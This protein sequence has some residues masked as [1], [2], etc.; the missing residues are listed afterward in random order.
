MEASGSPVRAL[1]M[2][3]GADSEM[4]SGLG[5]AEVDIIKQA[6]GLRREGQAAMA[7]AELY[8]IIDIPKIS[9]NTGAN[10][11]MR[12]IEPPAHDRAR[13]VLDRRRPHVHLRHQ[14]SGG[15]PRRRT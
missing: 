10:V 6:P 3:S 8:V 5:G 7:S 12:G 15:R 11:P 2:R 13:R 9:T 4:T 14:R 1:V